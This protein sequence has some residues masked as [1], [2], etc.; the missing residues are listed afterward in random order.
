MDQYCHY[1]CLS[2]FPPAILV[3]LLLWVSFYRS[4]TRHP[5]YGNL[6]WCVHSLDFAS[7]LYPCFFQLDIWYPK[8]HIFQTQASCYFKGIPNGFPCRIAS[9]THTA[10]CENF[11]NFSTLSESRATSQV[12]GWRYC[13]LDRK[14]F[15]NYFV[16]VLVLCTQVNMMFVMLLGVCLPG[17]DAHS[18]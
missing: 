10:C 4:C 2:H 16:C 13:M 12:H 1:P 9:F 8:R 15:G 3:M 14:P 7:D 6:N 11:E 18:K 5:H 17:V